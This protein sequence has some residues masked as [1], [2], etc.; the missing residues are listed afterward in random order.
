VVFSDA[1]TRDSVLFNL[2][3]DA[4]VLLLLFRRQ[5]G[6]FLRPLLE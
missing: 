1:D 3:I 5:G 2:G 4:L 6:V